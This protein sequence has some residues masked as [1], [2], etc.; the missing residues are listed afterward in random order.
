MD[1]P[2][3]QTSQCWCLVYGGIPGVNRHLVAN[4]LSKTECIM[5]AGRHRDA[6]A[7]TGYY[8]RVHVR[9]LYRTVLDSYRRTSPQLEPPKWVG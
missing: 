6:L 1:P 8:V 7:C 2:I 3:A 5:I 4:R 9:V